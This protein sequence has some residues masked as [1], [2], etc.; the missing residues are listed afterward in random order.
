[1]ELAATPSPTQLPHNNQIC[2]TCRAYF[3]F[4]TVYLPPV[5]Q[6]GYARTMSI[7]I[8]NTDENSAANTANRKLAQDCVD[9]EWGV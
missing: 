6:L 8:P 7:T 9:D 5:A 4:E 2:F 1:M 3:P